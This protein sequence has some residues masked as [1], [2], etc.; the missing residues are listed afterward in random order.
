[1]QRLNYC[2]SRKLGYWTDVALRSL[3][4]Y[5][6]LQYQGPSLNFAN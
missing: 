1:M 2:F 3:I 6:E 4:I 5:Q